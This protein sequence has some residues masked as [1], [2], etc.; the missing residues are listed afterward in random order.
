L[1]PKTPLHNNTPQAPLWI[2]F[3]CQRLFWVDGWLCT[4]RQAMQQLVGLRRFLDASAA[5][6]MNCPCSR[7]ATAP[8]QCPFR[9]KK[10]IAMIQN[11]FSPINQHCV[12]AKNA[13]HILIERVCMRRRD[14]ALVASP[15]RHLNTIRSLKKVTLNI[16]TVLVFV[17]N[18]VLGVFHEIREI[19]QA[20]HS[21]P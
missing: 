17:F 21:K 5:E 1:L 16:L 4:F 15:K 13:N 20:S 7:N 14:T 18:T 12:F 3:L 19:L 11:N 10:F 9:Y 2:A 6:S 8:I